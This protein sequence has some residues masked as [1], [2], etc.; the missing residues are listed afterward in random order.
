MLVARRD[1]LPSDAHE[2]AYG[3]DPAA[4][5]P[6]LARTVSML[7]VVGSLLAI[8]VGLASAY[9]I[10]RANFSVETT[11]QALR[12]N[13][14]SMIDERVD[15][16]TRRMLARRDVEKFERTC[17]AIDPDAT[18][19][20]KHL[21]AGEKPAVPAAAPAAKRAEAPAQEPAYKAELH[22]QT[23]AKQPPAELPPT[24]WPTAASE[25]ARHDAKLSDAQWLD[26]VRQ[27][28]LTHEAN[29]PMTEADRMP[30]APSAPPPQRPVQHEAVAPVAAPPVAAPAPVYA[31]P[32][33]APTIAPAAPALPPA[34]T[35]AAP[36]APLADAD[37]PV[38]PAAIPSP[39]QLA[40]MKSPE[41]RSLIGRWIARVPLLGP[42]WEN[43]RN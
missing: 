15:A 37:H 18:A 25:R 1:S 39:E 34:A 2:A 3:Q 31:P 38:P 17:G 21:L 10:Y 22:P 23:V 29:R 4:G 6:R 28:L 27:A 9:S 32:V 43:G 40:A 41:H 24:S 14:I 30:V 20:F 19:A 11:C 13:I 42:V 5:S 33:A 26:A 8:P 35:V 16:S 7:Q 36:P 12:G